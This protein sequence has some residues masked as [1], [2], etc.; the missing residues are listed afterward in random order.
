MQK[1]EAELRG[2][3][4]TVRY[5]GVAKITEKFSLCLDQAPAP[6]KA[7]EDLQNIVDMR[8]AKLNQALVFDA[9]MPR[10]DAHKGVLCWNP[11]QLKLEHSFDSWKG[12]R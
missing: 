12:C 4:S 2:P 10:R 3:T 9:L 11:F 5:V 8:T 7:A 1:S 6:V